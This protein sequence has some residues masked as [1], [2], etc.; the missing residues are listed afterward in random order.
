[1]LSFHQWL[2]VDQHFME[3]LIPH[4]V[5][6]ALNYELLQAD[7]LTMH[8]QS[9]LDEHVICMS[10]NFF[11]IYKTIEFL[12]NIRCLYSYDHLCVSSRLYADN[13]E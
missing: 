5:T 3:L 4:Q 11:I 13:F 2:Y 1:M 12:L 6:C 8:F 10:V 7:A 9:Q